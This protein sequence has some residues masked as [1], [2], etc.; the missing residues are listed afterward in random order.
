MPCHPALI[1]IA[2]QQALGS[3]RRGAFQGNFH[4]NIIGIPGIRV[5]FTT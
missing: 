2:R 1:G 5:V 4:V 3:D